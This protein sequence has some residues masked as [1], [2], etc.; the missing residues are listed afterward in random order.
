MTSSQFRVI[1]MM[2][3]EEDLAA[4]AEYI[5]QTRSV[6]EAL[7]TVEKIEERAHSLAEFPLRGS[8]PV[9]FAELGNRDYRQILIAPY[10]L[11]YRVLDNSVFVMLIADGR[12]DMRVLLRHRL[13]A[14]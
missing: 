9:E 10:R 8:V 3:A 7:A 6:D 14:S 12:R 1:F 4:I 2:K 11:I 5:A 13:L